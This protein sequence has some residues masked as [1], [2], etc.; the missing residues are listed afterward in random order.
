MAKSKKTAIKT[1][2]KFRVRVVYG[3]IKKLK[4]VVLGEIIGGQIE[5]GMSVYA[6]LPHG[7]IIG[8]WEIIE[9]LKMDFINN[10]VENKNF[11]GL[12]LKCK[13]LE[14]FELLQSLRV[15]DEIIEIA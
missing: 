8:T 9:I 11:I 14:D 15:Y 7:T 4:I 5:E 2:A 3:F 12:M 13:T 1:P 6:R 10:S